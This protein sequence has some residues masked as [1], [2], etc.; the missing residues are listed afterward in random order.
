MNVRRGREFVSAFFSVVAGLV[1]VE[2]NGAR[3][4]AGDCGNEYK[5]A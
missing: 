2:A 4:D 5:T 1:L 3:N